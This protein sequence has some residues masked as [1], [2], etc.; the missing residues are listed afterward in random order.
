[1]V[2]RAFVAWLF[3]GRERRAHQRVSAHHPRPRDG[4]G[5]RGLF[6]LSQKSETT[7]C[8]VIQDRGGCDVPFF[9]AV[10]NL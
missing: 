7:N 6:V 5:G 8:V 3:L 2:R 1:M 4:A 10:P 9:R